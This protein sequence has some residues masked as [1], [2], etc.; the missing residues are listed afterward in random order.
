M[1]IFPANT[2]ISALRSPTTGVVLASARQ[3]TRAGG[4]RAGPLLR[5][6]GA[7]D[8]CTGRHPIPVPLCGRHATVSEASPCSEQGDGAEAPEALHV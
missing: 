4:P 2:L 3:T 1:I 5:G 6:D 7:G 8:R